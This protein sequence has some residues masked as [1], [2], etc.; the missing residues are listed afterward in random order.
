MIR[1]RP[2][3][4]VLQCDSD[5]NCYNVDPTGTLAPVLVAAPETTGPGCPVGIPDCG[6]VSSVTSAIANLGGQSTI[7]PMTV[8]YV[9]LG[10][11][12]VVLLGS[13][14]RR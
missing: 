8:A 4:G 10:L 11:V 6:G 13:R 14:G 1:N 5:G 9:G 3:M 2:R 7:S 12:A